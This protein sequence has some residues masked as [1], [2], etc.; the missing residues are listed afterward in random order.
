MSQ[1][2]R[3]KNP[4]YKGKTPWLEKSRQAI[5]KIPSWNTMHKGINYHVWM[6]ADLCSVGGQRPKCT[7]WTALGNLVEKWEKFQ[8]LCLSLRI[9][10]Q[11][12]R[13]YA[14]KDYFW[15]TI[16]TAEGWWPSA[17][18]KHQLATHMCVTGECQYGKWKVLSECP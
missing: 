15:A 8:V 18:A 17:L 1:S 14:C 7:V 9:P 3:K 2:I 4:K 10:L 16:Q 11:K 6:P 12:Q 5:G 13:D